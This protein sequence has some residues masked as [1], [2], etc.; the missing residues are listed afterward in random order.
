MKNEN[1]S[2]KVILISIFLGIAIL[3]SI[4][5]F[6]KPKKNYN[7]P[8]TF[9]V[10][11]DFQCPACSAYHSVYTELKGEYSSDNVE[12]IFRNYP[13][14]V[15]HPQSHRRHLAAVAAAKQNK[16]DEYSELLFESYSENYGDLKLVDF[17]QKLHLDIPQFTK[18]LNS[19]EIKALV[20]GD[21]ELGESREIH[22]TPT[23]MING[24]K[25]VFPKDKGPK[26][27]LKERIEFYIQE[28]MK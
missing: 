11:T 2:G 13:L 25:V 27:Y 10:F 5:I 12:F 18:D 16:F 14:S 15:I 9:E 20:D 24:E 23:F 26:E 28:A 1:N 8:I 3:F 4:A 7:L 19:D 17:A 22:A 6:V 21:I